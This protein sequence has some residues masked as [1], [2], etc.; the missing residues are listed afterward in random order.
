MCKRQLRRGSPF[1]PLL[2]GCLGAG[3]IGGL[4]HQCDGKIN[5]GLVDGHA[6]GCSFG[7]GLTSI[8]V[9]GLEEQ[10]LHDEIHHDTK[11]LIYFGVG[12]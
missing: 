4:D 11:L 12:V 10:D 8:S 2:P 7:H 6:E 5:A 9:R 1:S 3:H